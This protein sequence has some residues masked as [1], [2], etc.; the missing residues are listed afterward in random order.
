MSQCILALIDECASTA[1]FFLS[2]YHLNSISFFCL[3]PLKQKWAESLDAVKFGQ[4][5]DVQLPLHGLPL[6]VKDNILVE[7]M[8]STLG[9]RKNV[10]QPAQS[11]AVVIQLLKKLGAIPFVR[12]NASQLCLT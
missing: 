7:G 3:T 8:D 5:S 11:D 2:Q 6:S 4:M 9:L 12:T 1:D 10:G